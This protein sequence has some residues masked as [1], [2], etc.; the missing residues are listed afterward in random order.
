[1]PQ[2][3]RG[4]YW[5]CALLSTLSTASVA[6]TSVVSHQCWY[7]AIEVAAVYV[8]GAHAR[9]YTGTLQGISEQGQCHYA[10]PK[11]VV[12]CKG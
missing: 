6:A 11:L 3:G 4:Y 10:G 12:M 7:D 2:E 1:M 5:W 9:I 8:Q